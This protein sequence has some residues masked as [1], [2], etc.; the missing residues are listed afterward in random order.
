MAF[1]LL[2]N[3]CI[4]APNQ[5]LGPDVILQRVVDGLLVHKAPGDL[6]EELDAWIRLDTDIATKYECIDLRTIIAKNSKVT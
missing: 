3:L 6:Q 5:E 2:T 4:I 1:N